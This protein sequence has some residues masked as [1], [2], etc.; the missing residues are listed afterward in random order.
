MGTATDWISNKRRQFSEYLLHNIK[1]GRQ[2]FM[3]GKKIRR[4]LSYDMENITRRGPPS[5]YIHYV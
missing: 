5:S 2:S 4:V 1:K 3:L